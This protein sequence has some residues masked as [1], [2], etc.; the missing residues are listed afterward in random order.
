MKKVRIGLSSCI[1]PADPQRPLFK[2]KALAFMVQPMG[3]WLT[4]AGALTYLIPP[5]LNEQNLQEYVD[6]IDGLL[7]QGG[8]DVA[9]ESYG[10]KALDPA[11]I[12]DIERDKI[13]IELTL[14]CFKKGVPILGV[15]RGMQLLNVAFGGTM[16]QD[17]NTQIPGSL[18]HRNWEIYDQNFHQIEIR[19]ETTLSKIYPG[20]KEAKVNTVHHQ[21]VDKVAKDFIVSATCPDDGVIEAI[22]YKDKERMVMGIQWHPEFQDP[23]DHSL[24]SPSV[25]AK[26]FIQAATTYKQNRAGQ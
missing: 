14:A 19:E 22:E 2:G 13:E 10:A 7:L 11:W 24:L 3:D 8:T 23:K 9:P 18:V 6:D 17:I 12:G 21:S 26:R 16:Y 15:C 25:I 20:I 5:H 4:H 1:S